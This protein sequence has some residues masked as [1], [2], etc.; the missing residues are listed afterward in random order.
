MVSIVI[1]IILIIIHIIIIT[2]IICIIGF[3]IIIIII[4]MGS[5]VFI[6]IVS[7][8]VYGVA[9][10]WF[11]APSSF[12]MLVVQIGLPAWWGVAHEYVPICCFWVRDAAVV[13]SWLLGRSIGAATITARGRV[14]VTVGLRLSVTKW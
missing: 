11:R 6:G 10:I 7:I 8:P 13:S 2:T 3:A 5:L 12:L 9:T 4:V 14:T 1:M